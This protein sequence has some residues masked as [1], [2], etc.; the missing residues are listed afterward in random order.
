[1]LHLA[2]N[3]YSGHALSIVLIME[4]EEE[5]VEIKFVGCAKSITIASDI[6]S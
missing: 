3:H 1:M 6:N 4:E 5:M 2:A